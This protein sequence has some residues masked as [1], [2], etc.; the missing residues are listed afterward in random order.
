[1]SSSSDRR[2]S[3]KMSLRQEA[4]L[5]KKQQ[6]DALARL[7]LNSLYIVLWIRSHPP[8]E[9]DFHWGYYFHSTPQS[10]IKYHIKQLGS[11]WITDH[12]RTGGVFKSNFL[13]VLIQ[14]ATVA[15]GAGGQLDQIM[16]SHDGNVNSI[17]GVTCRVWIL[18][19]LEKLMQ[20]VIVRCSNADALLQECMAIG[21][22]HGPEA[23]E[24]HQPRPVVKSNLCF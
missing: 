19:I 8:H 9:N 6:E 16:R 1:M 18:K 24:N 14:I 22:Q 13:C 5:I 23:A 11:G 12:G 2:S 10:G 3:A 21:N 20:S 4:A 7:P 15:E 17:P